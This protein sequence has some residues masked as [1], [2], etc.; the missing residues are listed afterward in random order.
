MQTD[1]ISTSLESYITQLV[2]LQLETPVEIDTL[3]KQYSSKQNAFMRLAL[4]LPILSPTHTLNS[5]FSHMFNYVA[6]V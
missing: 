1:P 5:S 3:K 6:Y 4:F 2:V